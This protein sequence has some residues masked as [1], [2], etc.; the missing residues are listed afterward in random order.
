[1]I[2][3]NVFFLIILKVVVNNDKEGI[4][5]GIILVF[6]FLNFLI[7]LSLFVLI[8]FLKDVIRFIFFYGK[9]NEE[10]VRI[11]V[12]CL[13]YYLLGFFFYVGV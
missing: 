2:I 6:N 10:V 11:I 9:F 12:E 4:N 8:F 1:M 3:L 13:F 5:K 7:I